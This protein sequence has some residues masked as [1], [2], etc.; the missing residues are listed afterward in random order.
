MNIQHTSEIKILTFIRLVNCY[1]QFYTK[2]EQS[3]RQSQYII[4]IQNDE[5]IKIAIRLWDWH[6][7][8]IY[9]EEGIIVHKSSKKDIQQNKNV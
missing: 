4:S 9:R 2:V 7:I 8:E 3:N 6:N 5:K 1:Q